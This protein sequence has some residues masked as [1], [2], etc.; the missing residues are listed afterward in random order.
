A[1][2]TDAGSGAGSTNGAHGATAS[3]TGV[4][5]GSTGGGA[6]PVRT[7][8]L[9]LDSRKGKRPGGYQYMRD[10][11]RKPFIFMNAAGMHRDV[12]TMIHEAGHAFHS[13][14]SAGEPLVEYRHS[15]IEFAEVASMSMEHLT[16]PHWGGGTVSGGT[17][18]GGTALQSGHGA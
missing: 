14:L 8:C 3:A 17:A 1:L 12:M 13:M 16:I 2:A 11:A 10:R 7:E 6:G 5:R 18:S 15:P 9:D 4:E